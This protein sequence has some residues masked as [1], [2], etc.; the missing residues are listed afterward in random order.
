MRSAAV[1]VTYP[2][3]Q[4]ATFP[5]PDDIGDFGSGAVT[6]M[7]P[8]DVF[9]SLFEYGPESL[10]TALFRARAVPPASPRRTSPP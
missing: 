1:G 3:G 9:A 2:V 7:G 5:I 6:S 10:G 8:A 4:F